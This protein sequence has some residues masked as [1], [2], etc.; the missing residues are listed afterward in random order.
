VLVVPGLILATGMPMLN[1]VPTSLL[2]VGSFG[3]TT[4]VNYAVS[5]LV[6]WIIA[7]QFIGGGLLGGFLGIKS[8]VYLSRSKGALEKAFAA[9]V[10]V[11]ASYVLYRSGSAMLGP[12]SGPQQAALE[13]TVE[14]TRRGDMETAIG[15]RAE[16][17]PPTTG[18]G[19]ATE[20]GAEP[21]VPR[22]SSSGLADPA[23]PA[24]PATQARQE[25]QKPIEPTVP[26]A[27]LEAKLRTFLPAEARLDVGVAWFDLDRVRFAA[28]KTRPRPGAEPQ[29]RAIAAILKA[30]P[31]TKAIIG[32]HTDNTG[33][34]PENRRVSAL[35][36]RY[37][38]RELMR[39]GV[40]ASRLEARGYGADQPV[41]ASSTPAGRA[42]NR[43]ASLG[44]ARD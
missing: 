16:P 35:R 30:Y 12:S 22:G 20:P 6:D 19:T 39:M 8:G 13:H 27:G 18:D 14:S 44:V 37:V 4:A 5:G 29:L 3:L 25:P 17:A 2:A 40:D 36:A 21:A 26:S 32:G 31:T 1:A 9:L 11:V 42:E 38:S 33:D 34:P 23:A 41:A 10:L 7:A 28:G 15:K 43:R 24:E